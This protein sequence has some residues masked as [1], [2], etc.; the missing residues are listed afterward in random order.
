MSPCKGLFDLFDLFDLVV[1]AENPPRTAR[2][3]TDRHHHGHGSAF[4]ELGDVH[5]LTGPR[6]AERSGG[7]ARKTDLF[8]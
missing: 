3:D 2:P 7:P 8:S 1:A 4:E 5:R 6:S